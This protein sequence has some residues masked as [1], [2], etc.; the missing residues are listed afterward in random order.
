LSIVGL[1]QVKKPEVDGADPDVMFYLQAGC[2]ITSVGDKS[3]MK[4]HEELIGRLSEVRTQDGRHKLKFLISKE[5]D[6][7]E[8]AI[9]IRELHSLKGKRIGVLYLDGVYR[10]RGISE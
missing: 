8:D 2:N 7:P 5:V 3:T 9:S 6:I 1:Y 4:N 10:I